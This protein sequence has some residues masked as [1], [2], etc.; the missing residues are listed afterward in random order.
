MR[1]K[2][3]NFLVYCEGAGEFMINFENDIGNNLPW[4]P[5]EKA[6]R[7]A[8]E[9]DYEEYSYEYDSFE[10]YKEQVGP[11]LIL[12]NLKELKDD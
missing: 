3:Y 6:A 8:I 5:S 7:D 12:K 2:G 4:F 11:F 10:E 9:E 1:V